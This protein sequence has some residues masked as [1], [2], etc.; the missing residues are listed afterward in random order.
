G[1]VEETQQAGAVVPEEI[2]KEDD[3]ARAVQPQ[4]IHRLRRA[5]RVEGD[6]ASWQGIAARVA[7]VRLLLELAGHRADGRT[8]GGED[9]HAEEAPVAPCRAL[10]VGGGQDD[11]L[12]LSEAPQL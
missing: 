9:R 6:Q 8:L 3:A 4:R 12:D 11:R 1:R 5:R 10:V 2:R 7:V